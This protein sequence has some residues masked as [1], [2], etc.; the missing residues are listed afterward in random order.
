MQG[1]SNRGS[2]AMGL[3]LGLSL[4][5][6][7]GVCSFTFYKVRSLDNTLTV[8]GSAK[9]LIVSDKVK[10]TGVFTRTVPVDGIKQGYGEMKA[11]QDKVVKF[12]ESEG[13]SA[14]A[15]D[16]SPVQLDEP[17]KYNP[18]APREY[19]LRQTVTIQSDDVAKIAALAKDTRLIDAGV[20]FSTQSIEY[21]YSRLAGLRVSL[22][23]DAVKDAQARAAK[24]AESTGKRVGSLKSASMGAVQVLQVNSTDVSDY[25]SYDT[26]TI[27]KEVMV[28]VRAAFVLD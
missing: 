26:S 5:A 22:L 15:L 17:F 3:I 28:A 13:L 19:N 9:Q 16:I 18:D 25:G 2:V 23:A 1:T 7:A 14:D 8:T 4:I 24:I 27:D 6:A 11:D 21:Y 12:F 20:I 10:W